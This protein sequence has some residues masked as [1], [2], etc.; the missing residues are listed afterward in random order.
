MSNQHIFKAQMFELYVKSLIPNASIYIDSYRSEC[1]YFV[2]QGIH[3]WCSQWNYS[4]ESI[5]DKEFSEITGF[6]YISGKYNEN[7]D[8][9]LHVYDRP[10]CH[11]T[12]GEYVEHLRKI[13]IT[14]EAI[15]KDLCE[16]EYT[17]EANHGFS[18]MFEVGCCLCVDPFAGISIHMEEYDKRDPCRGKLSMTDGIFPICTYEEF[19]GN[20]DHYIGIIRSTII[21]IKEFVTK[22]K[23]L[24]N[25]RIAELQEEA[26]K[27]VK[28]YDL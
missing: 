13:Q 3:I 8:H 4:D 14:A 25:K 11:T 16:I 26:D 15:T 22:H 18:L 19:N 2:I 23:Y 17:Y 28:E 9:E 7:E 24:I 10:E 20:K 1:L 12:F 6:D 5:L 27:L 21:K